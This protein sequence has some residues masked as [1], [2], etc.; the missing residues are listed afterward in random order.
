MYSYRSISD[1]ASVISKNINIVPIDI[2]LVVGVP[3][4]GML[5]ASM[6]ALHLNTPLTDIYS[7]IDNRPL[8]AGQTRRVK[9]NSLSQ[10]NQ[11]KHILVVD[12]SIASG[13]SMQTAMSLLSEIK[14]NVKITY[15]CIYG[16]PEAKSIVDIVFENVSMPRVFEWNIFHH[17]VVES[18]CFDIDGVLCVDPTNDQNDDGD[19]YIKFILNAEPLFIPTKKIKF[20]VTSRLEKYRSETEAWLKKHNVNYERLF[21]LDLPDAETRRKL[22][23]HSKFKSE[24]YKSDMTTTLFIE[25][26]LNQAINIANST[27]KDVFCT[28][29]MAMVVPGA[30]IIP[31]VNKKIAGI[32]W[33]FVRC[34]RY[35][36]RRIFL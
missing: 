14:N 25:S 33:F 35:L 34:I 22:G 27:G 29:T 11:A 32:K 36:H 6:I 2:D 13:K 31:Q 1:L 17:Q 15:C 12:D 30:N 10:C 24:V 4:S 5:P 7:Y 19:E 26:E 18:A 20:L 23:A 28:E 8:M 16:V 21:M 9:K 3:R